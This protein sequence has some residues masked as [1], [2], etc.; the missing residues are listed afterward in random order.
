MERIGTTG[1]R[2][3]HVWDPGVTRGSP[4]LLP[5][6]AVIGLIAVQGLGG[7]RLTPPCQRRRHGVHPEV[8]STAAAAYCPH[9]RSCMTA[10]A[11]WWSVRCWCV[12]GSSFW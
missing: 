2:D 6:M 12:P 1:R 4:P 11:S 3:Q 8:A 9:R 5:V 7:Q 10:P